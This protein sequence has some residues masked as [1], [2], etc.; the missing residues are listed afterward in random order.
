MFVACNRRL[1]NIAAGEAMGVQQPLIATTQ[2]ERNKRPFRF[3]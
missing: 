3:I 2:D 1:A